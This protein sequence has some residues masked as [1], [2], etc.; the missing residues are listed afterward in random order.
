MKRSATVA[1]LLLAVIGARV[2]AR[3]LP[4]P[5]SALQRDRSCNFTHVVRGPQQKLPQPVR[6]ESRGRYRP[7]WQTHALRGR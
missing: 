3:E 1:F 4:Q 2:E 7:S 6:D 5:L